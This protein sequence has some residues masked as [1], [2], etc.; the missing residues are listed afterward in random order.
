MCHGWYDHR[1]ESIERCIAGC[2]SMSST[3]NIVCFYVLAPAKSQVAHASLI[4][5]SCR[6]DFS[7]C[8]T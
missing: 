4:E 8:V 7:D 6:I 3:L 2:L 5:V 1:T